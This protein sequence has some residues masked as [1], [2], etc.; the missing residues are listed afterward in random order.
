MLIPLAFKA[1]KGND[2]GLV[3]YVPSVPSFDDLI[4]MPAEEGGIS[5]VT[6]VVLLIRLGC[7]DEEHQLDDNQGNRPEENHASG[8]KGN[9]GSEE[10]DVNRTRNDTPTEP[11]GEDDGEYDRTACVM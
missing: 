1:Y 7:T 6:S 5:W 4:R 11:S 2:G 10:H 3:K 9:A 8:E